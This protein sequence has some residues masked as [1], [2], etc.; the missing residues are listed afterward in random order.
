VGRG[1]DERRKCSL[2][3]M[4]DTGSREMVEAFDAEG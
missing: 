2:G 3:R 1:G 4:G